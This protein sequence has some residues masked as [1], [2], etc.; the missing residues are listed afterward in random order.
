MKVIL[1]QN[2]I[3]FYQDNQLIIEENLIETAF[4]K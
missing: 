3:D 2:G 1:Y 4:S